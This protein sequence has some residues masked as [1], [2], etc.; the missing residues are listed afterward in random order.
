[1]FF[2]FIR[3]RTPSRPLAFYIPCV[4]KRGPCR[5]GISTYAL[6]LTALRVTV[7]GII[8]ASVG[9]Q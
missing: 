4:H 9:L 1:M 8:R 6:S 5:V 3:Q 2:V 7:T